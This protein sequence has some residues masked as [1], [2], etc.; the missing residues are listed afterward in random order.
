MRVAFGYDFG[1]MLAG[2]QPVVSE[3]DLAICHGDG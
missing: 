2:V 3:A 1:P